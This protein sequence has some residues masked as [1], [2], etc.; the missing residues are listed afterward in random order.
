MLRHAASK[1][2]KTGEPKRACKG[3]RIGRRNRRDG[4][5]ELISKF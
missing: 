4:T 1:N 2:V 5:I 3:D